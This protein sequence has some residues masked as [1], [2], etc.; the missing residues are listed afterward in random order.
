MVS[1]EDCR[2]KGR[3]IESRSFSFFYSFPK[4]VEKRRFVIRI[5]VSAQKVARNEEKWRKR[6][7]GE[8][9]KKNRQALQEW[10]RERLSVRLEND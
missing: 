5:N 2:S 4:I 7:S 1:T 3:G 9:K 10:I 8:S 6:G